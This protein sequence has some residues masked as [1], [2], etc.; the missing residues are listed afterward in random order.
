MACAVGMPIARTN[1]SVCF[2]NSFSAEISRCRCACT[3]TLARTTSMPGAT[4]A[5]RRLVAC[6][7]NASA[8]R[9]WLRAASM[10]LSPAAAWK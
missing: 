2:A 7:S 10:R 9:T 3:C 1:C 4:P 5:L 6:V 8:V